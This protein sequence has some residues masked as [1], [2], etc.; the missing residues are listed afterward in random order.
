MTEGSDLKND[1]RLD[2]FMGEVRQF[3]RDAA[4]GK[5]ALPKLAIAF[6]RA[7]AD[8]VVDPAKDK[9]GN[10]AAARVFSAYCASEG[11]KA[12]HNRTPESLKAN[13]S[14]LRQLQN[15]A[16]N[17][18]FDFVDVLNRTF[19]IRGQLMDDDQDVKP[20]YAAYVDIAREQLKQ[21]SELSDDQIDSVVRSSTKTKEKTVE[22]Q[23]K[24]AAKILEDLITG[25]NKDGLKD[26]S[27]EVMVAAEQINARLTHM[28]TNA[29][30]DAVLAAAA[31][32]G[33]TVTG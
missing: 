9:D 30:R 16:S 7:V 22:G 13:I 5:D 1:T 11:K 4:E 3:G 12:V 25:E 8:G 24:K 29:K 15:A 21:D 20:A 14:K 26:D 10:D 31:E 6:V 32:L 33:M 18:K 17:P 2:D 19:V 23:L 27:Q 28:M